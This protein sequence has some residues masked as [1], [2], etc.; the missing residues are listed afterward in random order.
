MYVLQTF[1]DG[2]CDVTLIC[3]CPGSLVSDFRL[4]QGQPV[5]R[6]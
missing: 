3:H 4:N 1:S 5:L 6:L 2:C